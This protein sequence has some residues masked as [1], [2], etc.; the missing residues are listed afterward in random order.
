MGAGIVVDPAVAQFGERRLRASEEG[1]RGARGPGSPGVV[2]VERVAVTLG[3][4]PAI[5]S[6]VE[7]GALAVC[8]HRTDE[9]L[10]RHEETPFLFSVTKGDARI[11]AIRGGQPAVPVGIDHNPLGLP[12]LSVVT[13]SIQDLGRLQAS[14]KDHDVPGVL[15][16]GHIGEFAP[17]H[18]VALVASVVRHVGVDPGAPA[19]LDR[20]SPG[21][22]AVPAARHFDHAFFP[23]LGEEEDRPVHRDCEMCHDR[24]LLVPGLEER[25]V[26]CEGL[27]CSV[28]CHRQAEQESQQRGCGSHHRSGGSFFAS[29]AVA[30]TRPAGHSRSSGSRGRFGSRRAGRGSRWAHPRFPGPGTAGFA[31]GSSRPLA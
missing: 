4:I 1:K 29:S 16:D 25:F 24:D 26:R 28:W 17:P 12:R 22:A 8:V 6:L 14:G 10:R 5:L 9:H 31:R 19:H 18:V 2:A 3:E 7:I 21:P 13:A 20:R 23:L 30:S 15:V 27:R 11:A